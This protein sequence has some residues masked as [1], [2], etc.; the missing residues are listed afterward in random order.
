YGL[1]QTVEYRGLNEIRGF[2]QGLADSG[3]NVLQLD[4]EHLAVA[5]WGLAAHDVRHQPYAGADLVG[6]GGLVQDDSVDDPDATYLVSQRMGWF[7]PFTTDD[8]PLLLGEIVYFE[9]Q[10]T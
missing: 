8:P 4:I 1:G 5:D 2:Y 3:A 9:Q 7:F 10:P 6:P